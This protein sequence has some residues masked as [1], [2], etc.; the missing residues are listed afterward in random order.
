MLGG[1]G[2]RQTNEEAELENELNKLEKRVILL[3][4]TLFRLF[5]ASQGVGDR[6]AKIWREG[7]LALTWYRCEKL[8]NPAVD[9][10]QGEQPFLILLRQVLRPR[11]PTCLQRDY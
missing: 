8:E 11:L 9:G 6:L 2:K 1:S 7:E 5:D 3:L 4:L 10:E